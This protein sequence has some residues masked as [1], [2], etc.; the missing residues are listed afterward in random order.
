VLEFV[1]LPYYTLYW[2]GAFPICQYFLPLYSRYP[3][4]SITP[5]KPLAFIK[6]ACEKSVKV[7]GFDNSDRV[8]DLTFNKDLT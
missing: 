7:R 5:G 1:L 4:F 2:V 3:E 6:L 8:G